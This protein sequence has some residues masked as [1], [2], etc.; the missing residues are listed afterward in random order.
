VAVAGLIAIFLLLQAAFA[1][2]RLA[3]L[4]F[5]TLPMALGGAALA[6][7]IAGGEITLGSV[8]G[9]VAVLAIAVR[10]VVVLVRH[11]Q[12]LQADGE[13][14]GP[15]LVTRA[16][17]DRVAPILTTAVGAAVV[18]IPFAV[19]G[20]AGFEIVGPMS[21]VILGGL[22]SSTLLTLVVLPPAYL[23][24][25]FVAEPDRSAEDLIVKIPDVDTVGR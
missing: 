10:G 13:A 5:L 20:G 8:A 25:G 9:F 2:W 17:R 1:S 23:R 3:I 11:Y 4:S 16:T 24:F 19:S 18:F 22:I 14:F 15:D 7:V 12:R 6:A 21:A